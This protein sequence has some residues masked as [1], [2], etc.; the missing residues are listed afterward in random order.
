LFFTA[1]LS[2]ALPGSNQQCLFGITAAIFAIYMYSHAKPHP[3]VHDQTLLELGN[4]QILLTLLGANIIRTKSLVSSNEETYQNTYVEVGLILVNVSTM[5]L[6]AHFL[7]KEISHW[8]MQLTVYL[9]NT[10]YHKLRAALFLTSSS[11]TSKKK[12]EEIAATHNVVSPLFHQHGDQAMSARHEKTK[13]IAP[14]S[15]SLHSG[16]HG[17]KPKEL[18]SLTSASNSSFQFVTVNPSFAKRDSAGPSKKPDFP[19]HSTS[20]PPVSSK[21][22]VG[23]DVNVESLLLE[24]A[25]LKQK[26]EKETLEKEL[27]L[28][29]LARQ[30]Q[31][32]SQGEAGIQLN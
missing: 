19:S 9:W 23:E 11:K 21:E 4:Y 8:Y 10:F 25:Y 12:E 17:E 28:Q 32:Q 18:E 27:L 14:F 29:K 15:S 5:F 13:S 2:V 1:F 3:N 16:P 30:K 22:I 26:L 6:A 31:Q 20:S 24:L 7:L